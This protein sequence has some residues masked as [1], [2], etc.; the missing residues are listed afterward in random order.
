[1][2]CSVWAWV[3]GCGREKGEEKK[4][5]MQCSNGGDSVKEHG[6]FGVLDYAGY[7]AGEW[8]ENEKDT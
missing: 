6:S 2:Y 5:W 1:M 3:N 7:L 8:G 4:H